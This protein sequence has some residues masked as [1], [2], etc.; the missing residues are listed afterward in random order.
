MFNEGFR[1]F[2]TPNILLT[3]KFPLHIDNYT[4]NN[5]LST[6]KDGFI[7]SDKALNS[8]GSSEMESIDKIYG[9]QHTMTP[10]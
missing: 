6:H 3:I 5:T 4:K 7:V 1:C 9:H 2:F 10:Y 8:L